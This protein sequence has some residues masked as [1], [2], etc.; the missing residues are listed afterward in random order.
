MV[1]VIPLQR[2]GDT[3]LVECKLEAL[4]QINLLGIIDSGSSVTFL[5]EK[6]CERASLKYKGSK[7]KFMRIRGKGH[8]KAAVR[9]YRGT[10]TVGTKS[11]SGIVYALDVR[12]TVDGMRVDAVLG[13]DVLRHFKVTLDWRNG[14]GIL[15]A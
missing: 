9:C 14:T 13:R 6:V 10:I 7:D 2:R 1:T 5:S 4:N 11:G 15:E 3:F 8:R 12:P